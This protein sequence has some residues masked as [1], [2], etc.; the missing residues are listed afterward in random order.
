[1]NRKSLFIP[2]AV[3]VLFVLG[4]VLMFNL[5][6]GVE[7]P[8]PTVSQTPPGVTEPVVQADAPL[9]TEPTQPAT[10]PT[11]PPPPPDTTLP[12]GQA[13]TAHHAFVYDTAQQRLLFY[14][15]D[16]ESPIYPA[17]ITKLMT[18]YVVQKYMDLNT[19]VTVGEE[20]T[21]IDPYSSVAELKVGDQLSVKLLIYGL[22][23]PSGNDAAYTLAVACGRVIAEDPTLDRQLA[24]YVFVDE[25]NAEARLLGMKN[26]H[27][28]TAD[29]NHDDNH[30][31]SINDLVILLDAVLD[32]ELIM[33]AAKTPTK[34]V[35][36]ELGRAVT[37]K[38][39]NQLLHSS[40]TYYT[41]S[42]VGMK[43]GSTTAGGACLISLFTREEAYLA[44]GV[45][46]SKG[47]DNRY[48]DTL[49]LYNLYK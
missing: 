47:D 10:I 16:P 7:A 37:W 41:P 9:A 45:F 23:L 19:K 27:F 11:E 24:Y 8:A 13:I 15:G 39:S 29:G 42:A 12:E 4:L 46:G 38:N 32:N 43:T 40:A 33:T 35:S 14:S 44:V 22:M 1:M 30:Y 18:A 2:I 36:Q 49:L 17:S 25:M 5:T 3:A 21:W 48:L 34:D 28:V 20:I 26:T 31:T 6:P